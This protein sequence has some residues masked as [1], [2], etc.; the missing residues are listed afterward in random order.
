MRTGVIVCK[1]YQKVPLLLL[2]TSFFFLHPLKI[3]SKIVV[4]IIT[5][6]FLLF[7]KTKD[8]VLQELFL[9]LDVKSVNEYRSL[10]NSNTALCSQKQLF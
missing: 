9:Y 3:N 10:L 4:V 8:A 2:L 7:C 6:L 5:T 1:L